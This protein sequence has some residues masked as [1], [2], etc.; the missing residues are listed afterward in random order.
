MAL[1]PQLRYKYTAA[2]V[3]PLPSVRTHNH[4]M[5]RPN[6]KEI[7]NNIRSSYFSI[8][9]VRN[10]LNAHKE[11]R[12]MYFICITFIRLDIIVVPL[13]VH[14]I[15]THTRSGWSCGSER[16]R[17]CVLSTYSG[18][19]ASVLVL[20]V[21]RYYIFGSPPL[22]M[23]AFDS[24]SLTSNNRNSGGMLANVYGSRLVGLTERFW[25]VQWRYV[26]TVILGN[27]YWIGYNS[28]VSDWNGSNNFH[29]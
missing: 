4:S 13:S 25:A 11:N 23:V 20:V 16:A 19:R 7:L 24:I 1:M 27:S 12:P 3:L 26:W 10:A 8:H 21:W 28:W 6:W 2:E 17:L 5:N 15:H 29:L 9:L 14:C 22:F 18:N